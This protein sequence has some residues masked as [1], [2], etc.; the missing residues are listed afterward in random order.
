MDGG[1]APLRRGTGS[2]AKALRL[3]QEIGSAEPDTLRLTDLV[4]RA[5]IDASTAFR[6]LACLVD[7]EFVEKVDGKRYRLGRKLFELG[8]V[9][10]RHFN[11]HVAAR[12]TLGGLADRLNM[13]VTLVMRSRRETVFVEWEGP[14]LFPSLTS[15][16][17]TRLPIGVDSGGVALLAAMAPGEADALIRSNERRYRAFGH[18]TT[19]VLR[20]HVDRAKTRGFAQT[21]SFRRA[22]VGSV[23]IVVPGAA[24][25]PTLALS[26]L[27]EVARLR[28]S[29]ALVAD[30]QAAAQEVARAIA[31]SRSDAAPRGH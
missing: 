23:G 22:D 28:E 14:E 6:M 8:L 13:P 7:E 26:I 9:A 30:M 21:V 2:L 11:G 18:Y 19:R 20:G 16:P 10:G 25:A 3:L 12:A 1:T 29:H 27:C 24:G 31:A 15:P 17:G 5:N 4:G